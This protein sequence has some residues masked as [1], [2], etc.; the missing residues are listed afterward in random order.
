ME[1]MTHRFDL[2]VRRLLAFCLANDLVGCKIVVEPYI[3]YA[4]ED[5]VHAEEEAREEEEAR[6]HDALRGREQET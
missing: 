1:G 6:G 5:V 2:L 3:K 4:E